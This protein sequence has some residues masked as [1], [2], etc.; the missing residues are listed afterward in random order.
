[1]HDK[2]LLVLSKNSIS[3]SWVETEVENAFAKERQDHR[4]VLFPIRLDDAVM[5]TSE[6]WACDI[7]DTRH[8]GDFHGWKEH[9]AYR[10]AFE[11]LMRDLKAEKPGE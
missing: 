8:I 4:T 9:D 3:S 2:T 11:R 1:V 10:Q 5:A 7:Q 6:S